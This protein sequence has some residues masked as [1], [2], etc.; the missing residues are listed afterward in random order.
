[1]SDTET[2]VKLS[3]SYTMGSTT[4]DEVVLR[5]P[6][7]ADYRAVG[8][9]AERQGTVVVTFSEAVWGYVDRLVKSPAAGA[10]STVDLVDAMAIEESITGFFISAT[11]QLRKLES[12]S[13][14][15]DGGPATSTN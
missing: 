8:P 7:L 4:F 11:T 14:A 9:I 15:S 13:S 2:S 1:M 12:S 6:N 3:K 5:P 10:L